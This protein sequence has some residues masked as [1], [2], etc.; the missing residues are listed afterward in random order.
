MNYKKIYD[1]LIISRKEMNRKHIVFDGLENHHIIIKS[2]GGDNNKENLVLLTGREHYIAHLLLH[3][4]YGCKETK[5][6][7]GRF[8]STAKHMSDN[9]QFKNNSRY[10]GQKREDFVKTNNQNRRPLIKPIRTKLQLT[11]TLCA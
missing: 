8:I 2:M 1:E 9:G 3:K 11:W 10:I 7:I 5:C 4:I 6:S